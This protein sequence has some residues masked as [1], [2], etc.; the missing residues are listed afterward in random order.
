MKKAEN[1]C[2][3]C[4]PGTMVYGPMKPKTYVTDAPGTIVHSDVAAM[5]V[6]SLGSAKYFVTF[7]DEASGPVRVMHLKSKGEAGYHLR[8]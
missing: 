8:K 2:E 7:I 3:P 5:N 4:I 1:E 6:L